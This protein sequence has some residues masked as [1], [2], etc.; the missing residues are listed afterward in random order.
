MRNLIALRSTPRA[1]SF[2]LASP[3]VGCT[4]VLGSVLVGVLAGCS[5]EARWKVE[6]QVVVEAPADLVRSRLADLSGWPPWSVFNGEA[7]PG[8]APALSGPGTGPGA[9][10]T[11]QKGQKLLGGSFEL[12]AP[13]PDEAVSY[14]STGPEGATGLGGVSVV[15]AEGRTT[16]RWV[17]EGSVRARSGAAVGQAIQA[18]RDWAVRTS[19]DGLKLR[20]EQAVRR[21]AELQVRARDEEAR[22]KQEEAELKMP[23]EGAGDGD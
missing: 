3:R 17:D 1:G 14:R 15:E 11:W 19:L 13:R 7:D 5:E 8:S 9:T 20:V 16:V 10:L 23:K 4:L 22:R 2:P 12:T 6:H 18:E 21:E